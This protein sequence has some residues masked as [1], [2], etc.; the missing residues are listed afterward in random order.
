MKKAKPKND[1]EGPA[2]PKCGSR[3]VSGLVGSFW[4]SVD[5][6]GAL[7]NQWSEH[8]GSTEVGPER[9]CQVCDFRWED[10]EWEEE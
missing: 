10:G 3:K 1:G 8:E 6:Q 4:A 7:I 9:C 2:C 5:Q